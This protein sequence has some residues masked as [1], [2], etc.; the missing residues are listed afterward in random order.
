MKGITSRRSQPSP[1]VP[2]AD[3][4]GVVG[5]TDAVWART[6]VEVRRHARLR[7]RRF[8]RFSTCVA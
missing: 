3:G 6:M 7:V 2:D 1:S 5:G 8:I 4:E